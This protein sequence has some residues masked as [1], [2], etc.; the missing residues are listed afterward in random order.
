MKLRLNFLTSRGEAVRTDSEIDLN[1]EW[2]AAYL[3]TLVRQL[4]NTNF[5]LTT[6]TTDIWPDEEEPERL[7]DRDW[8]MKHYKDVIS[9][10]CPV[11]VCEKPAGELCD[12]LAVWVHLERMAAHY[13]NL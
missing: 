13:D 2:V 8:A 1:D 9:T 5:F 4:P 7:T 6:D 10:P 12:T 3:N 11:A